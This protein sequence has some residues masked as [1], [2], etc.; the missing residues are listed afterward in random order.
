MKLLCCGAEVIGGDGGRALW[1]V[2]ALPGEGAGAEL[3]PKFDG[4]AFGLGEGGVGGRQVEA[5]P[6]PAAGG[7]VGAVHQ[8]GPEDQG[9][10]PLLHSAAVSTFLQ[11][12]VEFPEGGVERHGGGPKGGP[13]LPT[14]RV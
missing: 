11:P 4:L 13:I 2:P 5:D 9:G 14:G 8:G 7:G 12:S 3:V 1:L 10:L 6:L